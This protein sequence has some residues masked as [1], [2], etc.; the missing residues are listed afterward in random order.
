MDPLAT[1]GQDPALLPFLGTS[2][3]AEAE[4]LLADLLCDRATR[5]I[6]D[7]VRRVL[8]THLPAGADSSDRAA[9]CFTSRHCSARTGDIDAGP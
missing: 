6:R 5:T 4:R 2:D 8:R 9:R 1:P 3:L 7:V